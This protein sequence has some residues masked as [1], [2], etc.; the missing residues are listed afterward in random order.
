MGA[1]A[2]IKISSCITNGCQHQSVS[3]LYYTLLIQSR[4]SNSAVNDS[5]KAVTVFF[6]S[7]VV[8]YV[9]INIDFYYQQ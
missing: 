1:W 9:V 4:Y 3:T 8:N 6:Q 2:P 5:N 7:S